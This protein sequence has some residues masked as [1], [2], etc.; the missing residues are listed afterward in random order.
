MKNK[1]AIGTDIGGSHIT[2]AL[3]DLEAGKIIPGSNASHEINNKG[4]ADDI[5]SMWADTLARSMA[6]VDH[7]QFAGIGFAM[8][9]PFN[10]EM[11]IGLFIPEVVKYEN[12][13]GVN[14][15]ARLKSMLRLDSNCNLRFMNDATSFAVGETWMGKA[16][17]FSRSVC[18]TLGTGFGSAFIDDGIPVLERDDV[19]GNGCF[20]HLPFMDGI[21][22]DSFSTRWFINEYA[23]KSGKRLSGVKEIAGLA[24]VD[25]AVKDIFKEFGKNLGGFMAPWLERFSSEVLV[26]GGSISGAH[27]LFGNYLEDSLKSR[28]LRIQICLS[29]LKEDAALLGSARL[30]NDDFWQKIK[31]LLNKM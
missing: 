15:A 28:N 9:G 16:R 21:V 22:D 26:I 10:Y 1:F 14:V 4:S 12:L 20:W 7:D 30:L 6:G 3:I 11:G 31:P 5:L 25:P 27:N 23:A 13:Y 8:P 2:S 19:P 17:G 29:H 24:D 18:I